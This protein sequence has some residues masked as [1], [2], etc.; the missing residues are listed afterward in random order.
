MSGDAGR[1]A[2]ETAF[3]SGPSARTSVPEI[4]HAG[5]FGLAQIERHH[6]VLERVPSRAVAS[7]LDVADGIDAEVGSRSLSQL[8][9]GPASTIAVSS[10]QRS[11]GN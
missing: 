7:A 8:F 10:Q 3:N 9:L 1:G 6:Q 4:S 11:E 2:Y 5:T